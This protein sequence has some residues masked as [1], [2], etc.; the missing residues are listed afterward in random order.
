MSMDS[1]NLEKLQQL[2][3]ERGDK[4][5]A[6][7]RRGDVSLS[8]I[9]MKSKQ[10]TAAPTQTDYN[11]LQADVTRLWTLISSIAQKS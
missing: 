11:N 7:V 2:T 3:G 8:A 10:L 5:K 1:L 9:P 4:T 6:A